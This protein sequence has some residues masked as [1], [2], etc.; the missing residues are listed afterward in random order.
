MNSATVETAPETFTCEVTIPGRKSPLTFTR[1][2]DGRTDSWF[3]STAKLGATGR[4]AWRGFSLSSE[5]SNGTMRV[6]PLTRDGMPGVWL[7]FRVRETTIGGS[8]RLEV[9]PL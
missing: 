2:V 8:P 6:Y 5:S 7:P 3:A 1:A 4:A 9:L